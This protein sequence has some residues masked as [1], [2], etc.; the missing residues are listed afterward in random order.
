[1]DHMLVSPQNSYIDT[2]ILNVMAL[3]GEA[4]GR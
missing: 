3:G 4:F 1:M 2:L